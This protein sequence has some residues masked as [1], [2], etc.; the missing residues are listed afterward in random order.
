MVSEGKIIIISLSY[1]WPDWCREKGSNLPNVIWAAGGPGETQ[2]QYLGSK[3]HALHHAANH[4][5]SKMQTSVIL[6][7][8]LKIQDLVSHITA[9]ACEGHQIEGEI[10]D[11]V[12]AV[13]AS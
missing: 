4:H 5:L 6:Q 2:S 1:R 7:G 11:R 13:E 9:D 10:T 3:S 12:G 8:Q